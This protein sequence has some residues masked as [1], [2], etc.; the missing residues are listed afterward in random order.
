MI[1]EVF[2]WTREPMEVRR[3]ADRKETLLTEML[4]DMQ[5]LLVADIPAFMDGLSTNKVGSC[6]SIR[7]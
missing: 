3:I 6:I 2:C 7:G 5:P 1:K 4:G